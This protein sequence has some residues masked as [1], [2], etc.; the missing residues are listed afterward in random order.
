MTKENYDKLRELI[1]ERC[2]GTDDLLDVMT[3]DNIKE[4][5][6]YYEEHCNCGNRLGENEQD[7]CSECR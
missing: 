6:E 1:K 3:D 2:L 4:A 7:V 5:L